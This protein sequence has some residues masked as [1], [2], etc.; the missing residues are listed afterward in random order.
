MRNKIAVFVFW[1]GAG[2]MAISM[3]WIDDSHSQ[4]QIIEA[5][6]DVWSLS[7]D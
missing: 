1:L 6:R 2:L 3:N 4:R 5:M 7:D